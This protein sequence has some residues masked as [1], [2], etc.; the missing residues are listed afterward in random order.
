M[1]IES[2]GG[3]SKPRLLVFTDLDGTLLNHDDYSWAGAA[4]ALARLKAD[5]IPLILVSSK[6]RPEMEALRRDL[7]NDHPFVVENGGAIYLPSE[8]RKGPPLERIVLGVDRS[9][10]LEV[11]TQLREERNFQFEGFADWTAEEVARRTGLSISAAEAARQRDATEPLLWTDDRPVEELSRAL[12]QEGLRLVAGGRFLHAMGLFDKGL[13]VR[14]LIERYEDRHGAVTTVA[15]GDS[16]N[17]IEMLRSAHFAVVLPR[18]GGPSL[19]NEQVSRDGRSP[20]VLR[21][22]RSGAAGW[23]QAMDELFER[24]NV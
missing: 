23:Q 11:L 5:G 22:D 24:L 19:T 17:D 7:G 2:T 15:V 4:D 1:T 16:P 8:S 21:A 10:I 13:A 12:E 20:Q 18:V 14:W 6:T 3:R 9:S